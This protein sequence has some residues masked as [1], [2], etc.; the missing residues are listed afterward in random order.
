MLIY[1]TR[2]AS[3]LKKNMEKCASWTRSPIGESRTDMVMVTE[4]E[5]T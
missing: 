3:F 2:C 5:L 1:G 4:K